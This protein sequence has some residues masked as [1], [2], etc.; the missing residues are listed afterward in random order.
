MSAT[1]PGVTE[2]ACV[3]RPRAGRKLL[4]NGLVLAG[5]VTV[6]LLVFCALFTPL[7]APHNP[8]TQFDDGLDADGMPLAPS[9]RFPL[10]TD[11]LGRDVLS[12]V[13]YGSRISLTVGTVAM[14]AA[15]LIG[16]VIGLLAGYLGRCERR[17]NSASGGGRKARHPRHE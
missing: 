1:E 5:L 2:T 7:V 11:S 12:R 10:G 15:A 8:N 9:S 17:S 14:L 6:I 16:T 3:A 4:G 13:L